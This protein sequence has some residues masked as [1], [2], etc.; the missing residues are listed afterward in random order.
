MPGFLLD[1]QLPR[2]LAAVL[3]AEGSDVLHVSALLPADAS[4]D[5]IWQ[6]AQ[7]NG[8][9]IVS[10]DEDFAWRVRQSSSGPAVVWIRT[11]NCGNAVLKRALAEAFPDIVRL[12]E[13]GER[14]IEVRA[15]P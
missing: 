8:L 12:L 5:A 6:E 4:D 11:G 10:K 2:S 15:G 1:A 7:R 3:M 14:L 13:Y 9:V